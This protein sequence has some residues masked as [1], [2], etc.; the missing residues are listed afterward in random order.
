MCAE[1]AHKWCPLHVAAKFAKKDCVRSMLLNGAN[2]AAS[3]QFEGGYKKTAL[4]I[5]DCSIVNPSAFLEEVFDSCIKVNE[6]PLSSANCVVTVKYIILQP[7]CSDQRPL[8]VLESLLNCGKYS[9]KENLLLHPLVETFL[10]LKWKRLRVFFILMMLLYSIFTVSLTTMSVITFGSNSTGN[11]NPALTS[12]V[13]SGCS[14][15]L[16]TS[17]ILIIIQVQYQIYCNNCSLQ[18]GPSII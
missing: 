6:Y 8:M 12:K 15:T 3:V 17:L 9:V 4:D 5:I 18:L 16:C 10:H 7:L 1:N 11:P 2:L 13:N 14:L